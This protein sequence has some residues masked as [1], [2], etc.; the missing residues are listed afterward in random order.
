MECPHCKKYINQME[1]LEKEV[2]KL[3]NSNPQYTDEEIKEMHV[4]L[5]ES[6]IPKQYTTELKINPEH[7]D[8]ITKWLLAHK[9]KF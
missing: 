9:N 8:E 2:E 7:M 5:W 6:I 1:Y 3:Y 4:K